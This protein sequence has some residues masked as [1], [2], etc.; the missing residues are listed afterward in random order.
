MGGSLY[1]KLIGTIFDLLKKN[2]SV[3]SYTPNIEECVATIHDCLRY[4]LIFPPDQYT[5]AVKQIE[6]ELLLSKGHAA[7]SIKFKNYWR[8]LDGETSYQG[9]DAQVCLNPV[10]D[11]PVGE[12]PV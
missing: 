12:K 4:T 2:E 5:A 8:K 3:P 10:Q 11:L 7:K 1:R 9:I 6:T